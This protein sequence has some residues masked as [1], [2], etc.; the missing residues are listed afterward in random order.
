MEQ[1]IG[2]ISEIAIRKEVCVKKNPNMEAMKMRGK[3]LIST[4]SEGMKRESNQNSNPAPMERRANR[5]NGDN[6]WLPVMSLQT[7]IFKP[8]MA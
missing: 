3:S 1:S 4:F 8:K 7:I 2:V 6:R 5:A